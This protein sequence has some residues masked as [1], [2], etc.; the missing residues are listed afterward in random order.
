VVP[1]NEHPVIIQGGMGVG[2]S[3]WQLANAVARA[4]Q[5]G[6][7][8]G[9]CIDSVVARRLQ[10]GDIGGHIRRAAEHFPLPEI[11]QSIISRYFLPN[12]RE[13]NQP[14]RLLPMFREKKELPRLHLAVF[15]ACVE[16]FLAKEGHS[17][18]VGINLLTKIQLPNLSTIYGAMLAGVDYLLMGAGIPRDIPAVLE[19]Y[20][21]HQEASMIIDEEGARGGEPIKV[22]FDPKDLFA[23]RPAMLSVPKFL[24]IISTHTLAQMLMKKAPGRIAGFVVE[25]PTA[26]GHNA[27]PRDGLLSED[28]EPL[29]GPRDQADFGKLKSLGLPFW[30]AGGQ[31]SP[32]EVAAALA[33]GAA[34]VQVGTLF[35]FSQESGIR[36]DMKQVAL[37]AALRKEVVVKTDGRASPTGFPFKVVRVPGTISEQPVY[38]SR[39]RNC[40]LGYLRTA[41]RADDGAVVFRC[42]AEPVRDYLAKGGKEEETVG[43]KCLCNALFSVIGIGQV[44]RDG[45][46][47]LPL[48]TSGDQLATIYPF[49]ERHGVEYSASTVVE[50]LMTGVAQFCAASST[51]PSL[52]A[53]GAIG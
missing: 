4:G 23:E 38:E 49:L 32:E 24:P 18:R 3:N 28:G 52:A 33:L 16:V 22:T 41:C 37:E 7:I 48:V 9:T 39:D 10:D 47:E 1:G 35:A 11:A 27:P 44:R 19:C 53:G 2:V 46:A 36:K 34:G 43:R 25:G 6:V 51:I 40:D 30:V 17:G 20:D 31:G 42:S 26:G 15:G 50:Y 14:Y 45:Y 8:S 13:P 12:G 21:N 29:Y 5:L